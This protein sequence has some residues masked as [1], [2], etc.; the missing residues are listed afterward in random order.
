M[1]TIFCDE[2]GFTGNRLWDDEQPYFAYASLEIEPDHAKDYVES[3]RKSMRIE[4]AELKGGALC[5]KPR[6]HEVVRRVLA[7]HSE[8]ARVA[9]F[10]KKYSLAGKMFEYL[11]EPVLA[12]M[13]SLLYDI[14]FH[15]FVANGLYSQLCNGTGG[16]QKALLLFESALRNRRHEDLVVLESAADPVSLRQ[17]S[18]KV[19]TFLICNRR[20]IAT[21]VLEDFPTTTGRWMLELTITALR[22]L[23]TTH[24]KEMQPLTV[25]CDESKPV[26][27]QAEFFNVMIGRTDRQTVSLAGRD[28]QITFNLAGPIQLVPSASTPGVQLADVFA[29]ASAFALKN[30]EHDLSKVWAKHSELFLHE[31]SVFPEPDYFDLRERTTIVN[32]I[33]FEQLI[34]QA[35]RGENYFAQLPQ[36]IAHAQLWAEQNHHRLI[37]T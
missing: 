29:S 25:F 8:R 37:E 22:T 15:K 10:D 3:L 14:G 17:F 27:E 36:R 31:Y 35:V 32:C 18:D 26:C 33:I 9:A 7:D 6:G 34:D 19:I 16:A 11:F 24:G 20:K 23:L 5:R 1:K 28:H 30:P 4:A 13:S 2:A 12:P 21:E